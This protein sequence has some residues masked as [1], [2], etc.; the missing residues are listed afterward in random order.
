MF[1]QGDLQRVFDA[2]FHMGIIDPVLEMDW[3]AEFKEIERNPLEL[4]QVVNRVNQIS[5]TYQ[6][7]M[8]VL[9][10]YDSRAL[11]HLAMLVAKE[12]VGFH[13]NKTLH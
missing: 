2:L 3:Q 10:E 4:A 5:G 13:T 11:S 9:Q 1:L 12:L 7:L 8:P 6:E